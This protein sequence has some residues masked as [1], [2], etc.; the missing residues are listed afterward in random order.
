MIDV[1]TDSADRAFAY[2]LGRSRQEA[3]ERICHSGRAI[4]FEELRAADVT[5]D[6][7]SLGETV[8]QS[9]PLCGIF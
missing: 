7:I 9:D 1:E 2:W 6:A 3:H 5:D 8:W 4:C